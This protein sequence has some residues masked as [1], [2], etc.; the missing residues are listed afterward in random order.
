MGQHQ[1][2]GEGEEGLIGEWGDWT[3]KGKNANKLYKSKI[4]EAKKS[5]S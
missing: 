5:V 1:T 4:Y 3:D 2:K